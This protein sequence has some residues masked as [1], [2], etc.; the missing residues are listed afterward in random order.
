MVKNLNFLLNDKKIGADQP[1][2]ATLLDFLRFLGKTGT[3]E[4]CA[5]GDCGACTVIVRG[6]KGDS[7]TMNACIAPLARVAGK[8]VITVEGL[9]ERDTLHPVQ[10]AIVDCHGS[11]CG[12]CTPGFVMSLVSLTESDTPAERERVVQG[13]SGNL[14][15]CTGYRPIIEAGLKALSCP[16]EKF[17]SPDLPLPGKSPGYFRPRDQ[18]SLHKFITQYPDAHLIAGGTDLMLEVTQ[19]YN[20]LT[21]L[22]D[23]SEVTEL[24]D[25]LIDDEL[26]EIGA[27]VTYAT[28]ERKICEQLREGGGQLRSLLQRLGSPQIR[29]VGTIGGNLANGSPIADMPPLLMVMDAILEISFAEGKRSTKLEPFYKG[30][31]KTTLRPGEYISK[32]I[33]PI[34]AFDDFHRFY[35]SSKR[36][37]DDISSVMGAFRFIGKDDEITSARIAYGGMAA[38]P[39]RLPEIE[40]Q[41][42]GKVNEAM[43]SKVVE[44]TLEV[45]QPLSDVRASANYRG[46]VAG[47][48]LNRSLREFIG[49]DLPTVM[50]AM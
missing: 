13:I 7:R 8:Q 46:A 6:G 48:M 14:C 50:E 21:T 19:H 24:G 40:T 33:M 28:V 17:K 10:Q 32:I 11:Q 27:G 39:I 38:T 2:H 16:V 37:E 42:V 36:I 43:I 9:S 18:A 20:D 41:L 4:G 23:L 35:K 12:F 45:M 22:I 47:A 29:N 26:I 31:R 15:R 34:S 5:S 49:E 1:P 3:K 44:M 30:Y 25:W